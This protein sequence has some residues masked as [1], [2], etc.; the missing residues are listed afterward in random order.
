L[1]FKEHFMTAIA[2][3]GLVLPG[4]C[5]LML[6]LHAQH[7]ATQPAGSAQPPLAPPP[8]CMNN[9]YGT[10]AQSAQIEQLMQSGSV[11]EVQAALRAAQRTRWLELGCAELQYSYIEADVRAPAAAQISAAWQVHSAAA[12]P[13][14]AQLDRCPALG[15]SAGAYALGGWNA[16]QGGLTVDEGALRTLSDNLLQTQWTPERGTTVEAVPY[17]MFGYATSVGDPDSACYVAG[18]VGEGVGRA[19][20][21]APAL[22]TVFQSGRFSGQQFV[23]GD[24]LPSA[25]VRDGGGGFDQGWAGVMMIEA[26]LA[27]RDPVDRQRYRAAAIAA[28]EWAV[29]EPPVRN[30]NYTAKLIWL[31]AALYDFT[32]EARFREA[33]IDKLER[34]L[35]PGVLMDLNADGQIDGLEPLRFDQLKAPAAR[36]PGRMWD[37]HNALPWYAA[38]NAWALI[39]AHAAFVSRG[40]AQWAARTRSYALAMLDNL[41][42]ELAGRAGANLGPGS[43][44]LPFAFATALW[45]LADVERLSR[46]AWEAVLWGVWNTGLDQAPGDNRTA[47]AAM[48]A[49]RSK[50]VAYR[51]YRQ[52][53]QLSSVPDAWALTGLWFDPRSA[54]EGWSIH[55]VNANRAIVLWYAHDPEDRS[56]QVWI[57]ADGHFDGQRWVADASLYRG[58]S[59]GPLFDPS[60][61]ESIPW[62][63]LNL[64]WQG[65]SELLLSWTS[66]LPGYTSDTRQLRPL[67]PQ[68]QPCPR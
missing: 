39:E 16:L 38:M 59:F 9:R 14:S 5:G 26:A 28:G 1:T 36:L 62:G 27:A 66:T 68:M 7:G 25:G 34:N 67:V 41:A 20:E 22:C 3:C 40:D 15:R 30:H 19:C 55:A 35:L 54:G 6:A 47:T 23:V 37:A 2:R 29:A 57:Y 11:A 32:G 61:V 60:K 45:K 18:V 56:R 53:A 50:G 43:S 65:C 24:Y 58:G 52:R 33:L 10:G 49:L 4:I 13:L 42:A 48:V 8:V 31:L 46:P 64:Q 12:G 44:Q 63:R 51:S 17:G 21:T